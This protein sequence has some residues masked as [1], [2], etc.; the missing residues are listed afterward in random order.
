MALDPTKNFAIGLVSGG[1]GAG[2][3]SLNLQSGQ[4]LKFPDPV[5]DGQFN[6][7]WWNDASFK[8]PADDPNVEIVRVT[9]RDVPNN[10]FTIIRAQEGTADTAKS[11]G[12]GYK[13]MLAPTKKMID[14]IETEIAGAG[15]GDHGVYAFRNTGQAVSNNI[16]TKIT[17][18]QERFDTDSY[19][20]ASSTDIVIPSGRGGKYIITAGGVSFGANS[21][22]VREMRIISSVNPE[23]GRIVV[24]A[25]ASPNATTMPSLSAA[26]D[27]I[28]GEVLDLRVKQDSGGSLSITSDVGLRPFLSL[29]QIA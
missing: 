12:S 6:I 13:I 2:V 23:V 28:V 7:V 9:A 24:N 26:R 14:D 1:H 25:L 15:A 16:L 4:I 21:T 20:A 11:T 29:Q 3:T 22:G 8:N 19:H 18:D 17:F 10:S 5:A 27:L